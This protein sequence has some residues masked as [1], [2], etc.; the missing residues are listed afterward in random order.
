MTPCVKSAWLLRSTLPSPAAGAISRN[1]PI[2]P[3]CHLLPSSAFTHL[4]PLAMS[5]CS[6]HSGLFWCFAAANAIGASNLCHMGTQNASISNAKLNA[7]INHL[8]RGVT[9]FSGLVA[10]SCLAADALQ[11]PDAIWQHPYSPGNAATALTWICIA[12]FGGQDTV[13][14]RWNERKEQASGLDPSPGAAGAARYVPVA[15]NEHE[16]S[17]VKYRSGPSRRTRPNSL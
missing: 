1:L 7:R 5:S 17:N 8:G 14:K 16:S 9:G 13:S 4:L 10:A 3:A 6:K 2:S 12:I 11:D 15:Q